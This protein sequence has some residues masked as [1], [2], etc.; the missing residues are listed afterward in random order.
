LFCEDD[1][2]KSIVMLFLVLDRQKGIPDEKSI[3]FPQQK[4]V[5]SQFA[6]NFSESKVY[7]WG[8]FP[9]ARGI[10]PLLAS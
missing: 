6:T 3:G 5:L 4:T 9:K 1:I 8:L 2:L 10:R 7:A